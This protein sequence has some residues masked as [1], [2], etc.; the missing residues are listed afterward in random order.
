MIVIKDSEC[1]ILKTWPHWRMFTSK[2]RFGMHI[3]LYEEKDTPLISF[4]NSYHYHTIFSK[5]EH[6]TSP[7]SKYF[8]LYC[9]YTFIHDFVTLFKAGVPRD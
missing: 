4:R 2:G 7:G 8:K 6:H 1:E 3:D 9:M 5:N